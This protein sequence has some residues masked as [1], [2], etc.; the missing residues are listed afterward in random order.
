MYKI[1][2]K[3]R[4]K[5]QIKEKGKINQDEFQEE[6]YSMQH[7]EKTRD[8]LISIQLKTFHMLYKHNDLSNNFNVTLPT[9]CIIRIKFIQ[10]FKQN[11]IRNM[12]YSQFLILYYMY[13]EYCN[14]NTWKHFLQKIEMSQNKYCLIFKYSTLTF[15]V[16]ISF[17][18]VGNSIKSPTFDGLSL[19]SPVL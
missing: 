11:A 3:D 19:G 7:W 18:K 6:I 12:H 14:G 5:G 4:P 2:I 13:T 15:A 10:K 17:C 9:A 1:V 8:Y 16:S